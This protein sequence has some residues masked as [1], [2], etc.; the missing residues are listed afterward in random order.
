MKNVIVLVAVLVMSMCASAWAEEAAVTPEAKQKIEKA[1][2]LRVEAAKLSMQADKLS[3]E[4][5]DLEKA[6][7][8]EKMRGGNINC[9]YDCKGG[10]H[11]DAYVC[12]RACGYY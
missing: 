10:R 9:Y 12:N 6:A 11:G 8:G 7:S 1:Q 2:E 4:A 5:T 3:R